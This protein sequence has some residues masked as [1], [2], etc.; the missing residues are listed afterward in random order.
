MV[1]SCADVQK[2]VHP[3]LDG[4]F[5]DQDRIELEQHLAGCAACREMVAFEQSFKQ[6]LKKR[7]KRPAAPMELRA[8]ILERGDG[9]L[10]A[11]FESRYRLQRIENDE[12]D[13]VLE[14][15]T[16]G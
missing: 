16:A 11:L 13:L 7:V 4:E 5:E 2:F 1:V 12:P 15:I 14:P 8:R 3:Y 6:A 10:V 9:R